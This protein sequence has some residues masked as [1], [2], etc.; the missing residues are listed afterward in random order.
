MLE[1]CF[2]TSNPRISEKSEKLPAIS[3]RRYHQ[4]PKNVVWKSESQQ[5]TGYLNMFPFLIIKEFA[6]E[7]LLLPVAWQHFSHNGALHSPTCHYCPH[8]ASPSFSKRRLAMWKLIVED[9]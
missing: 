5:Q 2:L 3:L 9:Q 4:T 8:P 1:V 7:S 6:K